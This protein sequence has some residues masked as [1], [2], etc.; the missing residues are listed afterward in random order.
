MLSLHSDSL[1]S[2]I[3]SVAPVIYRLVFVLEPLVLADNRNDRLLIFFGEVDFFILLLFAATKFIVVL[4]H[5]HLH[6]FYY[7]NILNNLY[8]IISL[9]DLTF[10]RMVRSL[11]A[12]LPL[13][14]N[15]SVAA[16]PTYATLQ[17]LP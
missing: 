14:E 8:P 4:P 5:S 10:P 2:N 12:R 7:L 13:L 11:R 3:V 9:F 1:L 6:P 15:V 16:N 17:F